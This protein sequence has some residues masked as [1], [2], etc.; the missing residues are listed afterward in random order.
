MGKF[1]Q[2]LTEL[3]ARN[4]IMAGYYSLTFLFFLNF[5]G[6]MS[7]MLHTKPQGHWSFASREKDFKRIFTI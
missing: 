6:P 7:P 5:I 4:K 3:S 1:R 2:I